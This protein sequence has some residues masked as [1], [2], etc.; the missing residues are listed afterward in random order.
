MIVA[1]L[2]STVVWSAMDME[3]VTTE[4]VLV[5]GAGEDLSV[6]LLVV[7]DKGS[8]AL[9]TVFVCW[10]HNNVTAL[11]DGKEKAVISQIALVSPTAMH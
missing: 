1:T 10:L 2:G 6:R 3:N 9:I 4:N 8:I 11:T 7:Q 5:I